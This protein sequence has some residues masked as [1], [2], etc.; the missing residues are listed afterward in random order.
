[1]LRDLRTGILDLLVLVV[2]TLELAVMSN[3]NDSSHQLMFI[4]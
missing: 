3:Y 4:L 1:M 2:Y